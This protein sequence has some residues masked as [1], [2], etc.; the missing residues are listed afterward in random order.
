MPTPPLPEEEV[1]RVFAL[2]Q[3]AIDKGYPGPGV[4]CRP[5]ERGALR[6][7]SDALGRPDYALRCI[8]A[9]ESRFGLTLVL[10]PVFPVEIEPSDYE[11]RRAARKGEAGFAPV[12][13]G[14]SVSQVSTNTETG[15]AWVK[16]KPDPGEVFEPP[17]GH[18]VKGVSALVDPDG[19]TLAKWVKT[20]ED[21]TDQAIEAAKDAFDAYRGHFDPLP[22]PKATTGE[23]VTLYPIADHHLG[24]YAW[25]RETGDDDYDLKTAQ[26]IL[27][28]AVG[29]LVERSPPADTAIILDL[30]DF[31][32]SDNRRAQTEASGHNLDVD[33][34]FGQV[35]RVA[36][37]LTRAVIER[38]LTRHK[39]VIY[40]KL[41]GNHDWHAA[42]WLTS[43][44]ALF[45]EREGRV[46]VV[47]D[48]SK[49]WVHRHGRTLLAATHGD[50]LKPE[51][52]AGYIAASHPCAWGDADFRYGFCG[53]IHQR[54]R[55]VSESSGMI[56]ET[57][58]TLAP[59][60]AYA[61]EGGYFSFRTM[62]AITFDA[63]RGEVERH[64]VPAKALLKRGPSCSNS[65]RPKQRQ[66]SPPPAAAS[67]SRSEAKSRLSQTRK[68]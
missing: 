61:S 64:T 16:Q 68:S 34:R 19:R 33:T 21:G 15:A 7:V 38:A 9:A 60:D 17:A 29:E 22:A 13:A 2:V 18:T 44:F 28:A 47:D 42:Q 12:M 57:M 11:A 51:H 52:L 10:P 6:M 5:G 56:V 27:L 46:A 45:Y 1:R 31:L 30:G 43:A 26:A 48:P 37:S 62:S 3:Q 8:R 41:G 67:P 20:R 35:V 54:R 32:H 4:A 58:Q 59:R 66:S 24:L 63:A 50:T 49:H 39:R 53:H 14:F 40:R 55:D 65:S 23:L 36:V 25:A